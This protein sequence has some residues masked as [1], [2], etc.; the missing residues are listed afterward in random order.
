MNSLLTVLNSPIGSELPLAYLD[1][2]TIIVL[3]VLA[4]ALAISLF[5]MW[6][7]VQDKKMK[8]DL[9]RDTI[10]VALEKGQ[11]VP[12]GI[13]DQDPTDPAVVRHR[14]VER[15]HYEM[16][17][18]L[19][20]LGVSAGLAFLAPVVA[21]L[22]AFIGLALLLCFLVDWRRQKRADSDA[23]SRRP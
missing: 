19:I 18:G 10:R 5:G 15:A 2:S 16:M 22:V 13:L 3:A 1:R 7:G 17:A 14:I 11:P 12:E 4:F 20:L 8:N 21:P 23:Q 9:V 6:V